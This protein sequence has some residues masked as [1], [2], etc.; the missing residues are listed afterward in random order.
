MEIKADIKRMTDDFIRLAAIDSVSFHEDR[1]AEVLKEELH[2]M[3][4]E[5]YEDDAGTEYGSGTGNLYAV[6]EGD[7]G[8]PAVL[9]SAHMDTVEPGAGKESIVTDD[10]RI[11]GTGKTVAG[12]DDL[13]GIVEILEAVRILKE[14]DVKHGTIEVL[15]SIAEEEYARGAKVFD[16]SRVISEDA[17]I[18][19]MSGPAGSADVKA[20]S[21]ITF[22]ADI[23]GKAAHA[24]FSP[25]IGINAIG[26]AAAAVNRIRQGRIED[27]MTL[28]IGSISGGEADN[29][30]PE[31]C[32]C[33]GEARGFDHS[34]VLEEVQKAERVFKEEAEGVGAE[35]E[36]DYDVKIRAYQVPEDD[37]VCRRFVNACRRMN[38]KGEL[39]A[40]HG[41]SDNNVFMEKGIR[42]IVL[43]CGMYNTHSTAEYASISDMKDAA[44]LI[45][46]LIKGD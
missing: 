17:Y 46:E 34:R 42:G 21:I 26:V 8:K 41:G 44:E 36:F 10:G 29:I 19:D 5:V 35:I 22:K 23:K 24:G 18:L 3:G 38:L 20:P 45:A 14:A 2:I 39:K 43:A 27:D 4:F 12:A 33:S 15:F 11:T 32:I 6:L 9:L 13:C 25:E 7:S 40:T 28:N 37:R 1:I 30:V 31:R 16:Y